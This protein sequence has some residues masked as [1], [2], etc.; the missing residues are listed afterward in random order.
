MQAIAPG[1]NNMGIATPDTASLRGGCA[2]V[3][4][5]ENPVRGVKPLAFAI[6]LINACR[7]GLVGISERTQEFGHVGWQCTGKF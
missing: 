6:A 5:R 3:D 2:C 1:A 4:V 7:A